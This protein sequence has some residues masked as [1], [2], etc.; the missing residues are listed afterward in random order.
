M[1]YF[2]TFASSGQ[3]QLL[4]SAMED[5][6]TIVQAIRDIVKK[7]TKGDGDIVFYPGTVKR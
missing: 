4:E 6:P 1:P 7:N 5:S 3:A 2:V